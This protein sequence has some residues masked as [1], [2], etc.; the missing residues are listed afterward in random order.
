MPS[1][2]HRRVHLD[3]RAEPRIV[4]G[5]QREMVRRRLAGGDILVLFEEYDLFRGGD[6]QDMNARASVS[7]DTDQ[8]F[9][10]TQGSDLVA[11]DRMR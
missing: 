7:R 10:A 9:S 4:V 1:L 2:P 8:T 3:E 11:P 5:R 6:V